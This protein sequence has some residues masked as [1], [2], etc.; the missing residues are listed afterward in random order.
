MTHSLEYSFVTKLH[1]ICD[2]R[3]Q[4]FITFSFCSINILLWAC[5]LRFVH[6]TSIFYLTNQSSLFF[7]R[8]NQ[9][10][11]FRVSTEFS[12]YMIINTK[13]SVYLFI[14]SSIKYNARLIPWQH[15]NCTRRLRN[16]IN[17][18][19]QRRVRIKNV[20][21]SIYYLTENIIYVLGESINWLYIV[22]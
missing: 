18:S 17:C 12:N 7:V 6:S 21:I 8:I 4:Y 13:N 2:E 19:K 10:S 11:M 15:F 9:S 22:Q 3:V 5:V 1:L 16:S 20:I 14:Y